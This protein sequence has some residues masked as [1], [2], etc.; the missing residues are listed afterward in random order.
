MSQ[1]PPPP[2]PS[3]ETPLDAGAP[4]DAPPP[5][6]AEGQPPAGVET[7][8]E[9][10]TWGM[11]CHLAGLLGVLGALIA[12]L[13]KKDEHPFI[14]EQ[15]KEALNFQITVLLAYVACIPLTFIFIG[16]IL[17]PLIGIGALICLILGAV[18]ANQGEHYRY[19]VSLRLIK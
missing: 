5:A 13:I 16:F 15:G 14:N 17:W 4:Q 11:I 9:A 10:K 12:W 8:P 1:T 3:D 18:K 19:P 6:P 7:N 2:Q